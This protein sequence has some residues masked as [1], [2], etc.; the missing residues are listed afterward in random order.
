MS[1][2]TGQVNANKVEELQ[3]MGSKKLFVVLC[4]ACLCN[5]PQLSAQDASADDV[6]RELANP[7]TALT[8]WFK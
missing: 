6:A 4:A 8:D 7:N 1:W 3:I 2:S 5:V